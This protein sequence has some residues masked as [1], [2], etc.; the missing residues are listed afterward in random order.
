M[1]IL[2][3]PPP[4]L[5]RPLYHTYKYISEILLLSYFQKFELVA[6]IFKK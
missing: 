5:S 3:S 2:T 1:L 6:E 4:T